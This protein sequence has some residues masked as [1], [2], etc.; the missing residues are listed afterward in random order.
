VSDFAGSEQRLETSSKLIE[1]A[2]RLLECLAN[3]NVANV[4]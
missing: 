3:V 2:D 1:F 4:M